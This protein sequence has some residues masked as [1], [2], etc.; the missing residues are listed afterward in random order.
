MFPKDTN[1]LLADDTPS[2]RENVKN[3]LLRLGYTNI[4]EA[5]DGTAAFTQLEIYSMLK[6][7]IQLIISDWAMPK[8]DGLQ[9]LQEVRAAS[10]FRHL[11]FI[12][13]TSMSDLGQ[14]VKAIKLGVSDYIVKPATQETVTKKLEVV[15]S[16][17]NP[18]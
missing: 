13:L 7:N 5:E 1:I 17:Q 18:G 3:I 8:M 6:E 15:W 12:L 9:F 11:P 4:F 2:D 14:V 10:K 16:K